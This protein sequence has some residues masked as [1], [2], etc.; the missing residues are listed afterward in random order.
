L[1][2]TEK[3]G[4]EPNDQ[5]TIA[6]FARSVQGPAKNEQQERVELAYPRSAMF[7]HTPQPQCKNK[8]RC[9][10]SVFREQKTNGP[11]GDRNLDLPQTKTDR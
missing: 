5:S 1:G 3:A 7:I 6:L 10:L 4:G 9:G 2:I 11:A 8:D